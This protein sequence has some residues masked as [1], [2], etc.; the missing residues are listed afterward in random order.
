MTLFAKADCLDCHRIRLILA[1]KGVACEILYPDP[2]RIREDLLDL[3]PYGTVPTFIDRDLILYDTRIILEYL[4]ERFPHPPLMP[5]D[6]AS[7][8]RFRLAMMRMERDWYPLAAAL[9]E[10]PDGA[11]REALTH[12]LRTSLEETQRLFSQPPYFL[13]HEFSLVDVTMAPLLWRLP[14]CGIEW[15]ASLDLLHDYA[16]RVFARPAFNHALAPAHGARRSGQ[17]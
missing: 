10:R 13:G 14:Q 12:R 5:V 11:T 15:T 8:G 17:F 16:E 6:P 4:D 7:R 3:N 2:E 9:M 1:E